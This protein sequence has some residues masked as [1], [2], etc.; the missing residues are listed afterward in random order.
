M[1]TEFEQ[2][3]DG[4]AEELAALQAVQRLADAESDT[5]QPEPTAAAEPPIDR[6]QPT[7]DRQQPPKTPKVDLTQLPEFRTYQ[8]E[9]DRRYEEERKRRLE[10]ER[11]YEEVQQ[12]RNQAAIEQL[13]QQA[14]E[15]VDPHEQRQYIDQIAALRSQEYVRQMRQWD[16]YK[17]AQIKDRG[18]DPTD[19]R[20]QR[21]YSPGQ[22]GLYEFQRDLAEAENARLKADMDKARQAADPATVAALVKAELAK[23]L[24]QQGL[25]TVDVG[26]P[27]G[28]TNTEDAWDRDWAA[29]KAG[30]MS[31]AAFLQKWDTK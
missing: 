10:L 19:P 13:T 8:A 20:F 7:G 2:V 27:Q 31:K 6:A 1:A 3:V 15:A 14:A 18:L 24:Q 30:R 4:D 11:M 17:T 5:P 29:V 21:Q 23:V 28:D 16:E 12:Q 26:T 22:V 9:A 25:N